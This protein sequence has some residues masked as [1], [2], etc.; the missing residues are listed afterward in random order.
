M[1][2]QWL[3]FNLL[4]NET[5]CESIV[6]KYLTDEL[7]Y[8]NCYLPTTAKFTLSKVCM[9]QRVQMIKHFLNGNSP[10]INDYVNIYTVS[11]C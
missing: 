9:T 8:N 2:S 1:F 6:T 3:T 5:E 7:S 4:Y 11:L 10:F